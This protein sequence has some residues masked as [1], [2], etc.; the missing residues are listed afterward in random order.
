[1]FRWLLPLALSVA[2]K[3]ALAQ[4]APAS[5]RPGFEVERCEAAGVRYHV[6]RI[7][8]AAGDAGLRVSRPSE[9]G[10]RIDRWAETVPGAVV[11]IAAGD[12][13]FP[14]YEPLGLTVGQGEAWTPE[15]DGNLAVLGFDE[16]SVAVFAPARQMV[17]PEAWMESVVSGAAVLE[18]GVPTTQCHARGCERRSRTGIGVDE[19]NR[20]LIAVVVEGDRAGSLGATDPELGELLRT[21]GAFHGLRSA[22]GATSSLWSDG[23]VI[24]TSSDGATREAAVHLAGVDRASGATTR[25]RGVVG[26][27][28][29]PEEFLPEA[30]IVVEALD[31]RSVA[32]GMP[33]TDGGYWEYTLPVREYIVRASFDGYRA[34]CKVCEGVGSEDVWCSLFLVPGD[35]AEECTPRARR[36]DVGP[37]P[38]APRVDAGVDAGVDASTEMPRASGCTTASGTA[39]W[40]WLL[41]AL[42]R[43][44]R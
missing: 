11:A 23:S 1:M 38:D 30:T 4:C 36:L 39:G 42:R 10:R 15:D 22:E 35:G 43:R 34:G 31:G 9:R 18:A 26:I 2:T 28:G 17:P 33:L 37:W 5:S 21:A 6:V 29:R 32:M 16:R 44:E 7:D 40:W 14:D 41:L 8:L 24:S 13:R 12:F 25:L 19:A 3:V 27:E 20:F